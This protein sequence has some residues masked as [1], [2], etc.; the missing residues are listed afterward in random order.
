MTSQK[1]FIE[2]ANQRRDHAYFTMIPN[3]L[4]F[5]DLSLADFKLYN[6]LVKTAGWDGGTCFKTTETLAQESGLSTGAVSQ[7]KT[8]LEKAGL[9]T[10][11]TRKRSKGGRPID[12]IN[13][14]DIWLENIRFFKEVYSPGEETPLVYSLGELRERLYS[15]SE[16]MGSPGELEEEPLNKNPQTEEKK[17][18]EED[19]PNPVSAANPDPEV[20][21]L[22]AGIGIQEPNLSPLAAHTTAQDVRAWLFYVQSQNMPAWRGYLVNRLKHQDPPPVEFLQFAM[23]TEDQLDTLAHNSRSRKWAGSWQLV[24]D[25]LD[26]AGITEDLAEAWYQLCGKDKPE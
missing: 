19:P 11:S 12:H 23:L 22:L 25:A 14:V 4:W 2:I 18:I 1:T 21:N 7:S 5:L 3:L 8:A 24:Y 10:R 15:L 16:P 9:I 26:E 17:E 6:T 13:I 20:Y